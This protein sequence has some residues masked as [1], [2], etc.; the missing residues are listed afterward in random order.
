MRLAEQL[1]MRALLRDN[2][3]WST[4]RMRKTSFV[5][6]HSAPAL[7]FTAN[8]EP[9]RCPAH[10]LPSM[11][12]THPCGLPTYIGG[13]SDGSSVIKG[14]VLAHPESR[15]FRSIFRPTRPR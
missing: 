5:R 7:Q 13:A 9:H 10:D 3:P 1:A 15:R 12:L 6:D 4:R 14:V 8:H 2:E 11:V